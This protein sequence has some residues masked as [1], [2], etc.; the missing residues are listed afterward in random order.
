MV[1]TQLS[2]VGLG[3]APRRLLARAAALCATLVLAAAAQAAEVRVAVASNF[4]AAAEALADAYDAAEVELVHGSTGRLFAQ[5]RAGAPFDV[6]LAADAAR[7]DALVAQGQALRARPYALGRLVLV[8]R[9]LCEAAAAQTCGAGAPAEPRAERLRVALAAADRI[10]L[11]DPALAPYGQAAVETLEAL[12]VAGWADRAVYG[13]NVAQTYAFWATGNV[14]AAFVAA[15]QTETGLTV[16]ETLHAPIVQKAALVSDTPA[17]T[18]FFDWLG[19]D[20]A[21]AIIAAAGY[22]LPE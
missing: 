18:A 8:A 20:P 14:P 10:A 7:P 19:G 16:P 17:A 22:G 12:G 9:G 21:R 13:E 5:I 1:L 11:A 3:R 15:S 6:L 2:P 4:L